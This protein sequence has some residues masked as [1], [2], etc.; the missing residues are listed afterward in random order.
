MTKM[1]GFICCLF[2]G[3]FVVD[4]DSIPQPPEEHSRFGI[5]IPTGELA[6]F[7][8][9][10]KNR[11][12]LIS[13]HRGGP[14]PG[15]PENAIE[16][17][18][19]ALKYGPGL[20]EI[21]VAQLADGELILMHDDTLDRTTTGT[22]EVRGSSWNMI[23]NLHLKDENQEVTKFRIPKFDEVLGWTKGRAI[24]TLDIKS[25][26]DFGRVVAAV[27]KSGAQDYV[28]AIAYTLA[29]AKAFHEIAPWMPI[30]VTMLNDADIAAVLASGIPQGL[31]VAW[32][33]L[34][35][36]S[37]EF[38]QKLHGKGWRVI[39]GTLG[40]GPR[41]I[42]NQIAA[43]DNDARYFELFRQ[44]VDVIAT[45]RFWA[46]QNQIRNPNLYFFTREERS[47]AH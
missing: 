38:Y 31:V 6:E 17:M 3:T 26:T 21:D 29:Q 47:Q 44:G 20:M 7:L 41:A 22:G 33:G 9:W 4:A 5:K 34:G 18:D 23:K 43:N 36:K 10:R 46:V 12:P 25:G 24:L 40:S 8:R 1:L 13:H 30:T 39:M 35:V 15:F 11:V 45:D 32:T 28:I 16:T 37:S 14:A 42:D 27:E 2:L 19:N